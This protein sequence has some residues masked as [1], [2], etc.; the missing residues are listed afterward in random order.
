ML[1]T[2]EEQ[3]REYWPDYIDELVWV[4]NNTV[5][6]IIGYMPFL[7]M[8]RRNV[9]C[10]T[11]LFLDLDPQMWIGDHQQKV[12]KVYDSVVQWLMPQRLIEQTMMVGVHVIV[13]IKK[14]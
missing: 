1:Q 10:P 4:Y 5:H 11:D 2:L 14:A 6:S 3:E 13:R 8:F 12:Q 9:R 7:I